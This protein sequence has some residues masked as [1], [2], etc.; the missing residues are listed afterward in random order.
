MTSRKIKCHR[1][2]SNLNASKSVEQNENFRKYKWPRGVP[3]G[4]LPADRMNQV[5]KLLE[6]LAVLTFSQSP[7][8][9][10]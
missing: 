6:H 2:K 9:K 4:A 1:D 3:Q 5:N 10:L 8:S 7:F